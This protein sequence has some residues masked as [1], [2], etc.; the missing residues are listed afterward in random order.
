MPLLYEVGAEGRFDRVVVV[1]APRLLREQRTN[2]PLAGR[3]ERLI[4]DREKVKRADYAYV[5]TG[6]LQALDEWVAGVM[7]ELRASRESAQR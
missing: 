6:D 5:N 2:V 4:D 1:T 7:A 3:E